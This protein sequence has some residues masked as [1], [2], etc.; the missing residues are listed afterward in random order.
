MIKPPYKPSF[1]PL[2]KPDKAPTPPNGTPCYPFDRPGVDSYGHPAPPN[3]EDCFNSRHEPLPTC[4]RVKGSTF[5][6]YN[7]EPYL[8]DN[9]HFE[10]GPYLVYS[11]SVISKVVRRNDASCLNLAATV[12]MTT[13]STMTN[14]MLN[15]IL[16]ETIV[17]QYEALNG[18][19]PIV[20][21]DIMFK[22]YFRI[23]D[24]DG[25]VVHQSSMSVASQDIRM[26][27]TDIRDR[28]VFSSKNLF[29]TTIPAVNYRGMYTIVIEKMEAY[30]YEINSIEH[31]SSQSNKFYTF[32]Q[33]N[34]KIALQHETIKNQEP[35]GMMLLASTDIG[36][37]FNFQANL[38]TRLKFS[39]TAFLPS[40]IMA[41]DTFKIWCG[42]IDPRSALV[43]DLAT[44][45]QQ[46]T[47]MIDSI[48][49]DIATV[50]VENSELIEQMNDLQAT[51]EDLQEQISKDNVP[52]EEGGDDP[53]M[54]PDTD[55]DEG[56]GGDGGDTEPDDPE[57]TPGSD[58]DPT[59]D[60]DP[61]P[62]PDPNPDDTGEGES[63]G[64]TDDSTSE[65][66]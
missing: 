51:V 20:K 31:A 63:G 19:L 25:I 5:C 32:I 14:M 38:T 16:N 58:P 43:R 26:H 45:V 22:L 9:T 37:A 4:G 48:T 3:V 52:P 65:N 24:M 50:K 8:V 34:T 35:D 60:P 27:F 57:P 39:F 15:S 1:K 40:F 55:P 59:P 11:E 10:Y 12:D 30:M 7:N 21:S 18:I 66:P 36:L 17:N 47:E 42:L 23:M 64:N 28:F 54:P 6:L 62:N 44:Q 41:P 29:S 56:D 13:D 2:V 33:E 46:L 53:P 49:E 61:E